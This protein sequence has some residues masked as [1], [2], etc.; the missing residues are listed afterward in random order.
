MPG[1]DTVKVIYTYSIASMVIVGGLLF[2]YL[3]RNDPTASNTAALIPLISG[4]IGAAI[5]FVFNRE[6]QATTAAQVARA[7]KDANVN[8]ANVITAA[9]LP[10]GDVATGGK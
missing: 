8:A 3:S 2:L 10:N 5:Q 9:I 6:T 4:F 7:T 1:I